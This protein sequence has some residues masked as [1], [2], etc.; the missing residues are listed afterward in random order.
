MD[1]RKERRVQ[2]DGLRAPF[3]RRRGANFHKTSLGRPFLSN[4]WTGGEVTDGPLRNRSFHS[5]A[6]AQWRPNR[7]RG[8]GG[9][10]RKRNIYSILSLSA[11]KTLLWVNTICQ[12][13]LI[14][15]IDQ[16]WRNLTFWRSRRAPV[17]NVADLLLLS[18]FSKLLRLMPCRS[19][20][21]KKGKGDIVYT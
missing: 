4:G 11:L 14:V 16:M 1:E 13:N 20:K 18:T 21:E 15:K 19:Q 6:L 3:L 12:S 7:E 2:A 17:D 10:K 5:A 9:E 8:A